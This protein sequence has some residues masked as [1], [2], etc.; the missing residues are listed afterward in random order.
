M[1]LSWGTGIVIV[2]AVFFIVV[3]GTVAF[4]TTVDVNLVADDYY[5]RELK[6]QDLIEKVKRTNELPEHMQIKVIGNAVE[7]TYPKMF[8]PYE[9][10]GS[11]H[12]YR[13]ADGKKD[14]FVPIELDAEMK[15]LISTNNI[16]KGVW[17]LKIDWKGKNIEYYNEQ[18]VKI[19]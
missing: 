15:Q 7:L 11:I 19:K 2:F 4:T 18:I 12:F 5:E 13:P 3:L 14:F 10:E 16:D 17:K 9:V 6:H 8:K 1:K